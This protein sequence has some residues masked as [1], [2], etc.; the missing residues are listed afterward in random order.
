MSDVKIPKI[1]LVTL[2]AFLISTFLFSLVVESCID[3]YLKDTKRELAVFNFYEEQK[4][5]NLN[6]NPNSNCI[7][8]IGCS[9]TR[10]GVDAYSMEDSLKE[11]NCNFQVYNIGVDAD[12]PLKRITE[13]NN[14]IETK[15]NLVILCLSYRSFFA[16]I[17]EDKLY[18]AH[19][20]TKIDEEDCKLFDEEQ[21]K[22]LRQNEVGRFFDKR[23]YFISSVQFLLKNDGRYYFTHN[24]KDPGG[25][26]GSTSEDEIQKTL[27]NPESEIMREFVPDRHAPENQIIFEQQK[28]ALKYTVEKLEENGINVIILN[29]PLNPKLS[30]RIPR[31]TRKDISSF[32]SNIDVPYYDFENNYPSEY[33]WD[34]NHMNI[35]GR[36]IFSTDVARILLDKIEKT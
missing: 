1:V 5:K 14:I 13:I 31:S 6:K 20:G 12:T 29:M 30:E 19:D 2:C 18:L 16:P 25:L 3:P 23:R 11:A 26:Y 34:L 4:N 9:Q 22:I 10:H 28:K 8:F 36:S 33:F 32:L 21:L 27:N 17:P 35:D 24:F 15:P 7:Y